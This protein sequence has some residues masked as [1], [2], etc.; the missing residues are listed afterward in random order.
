MTENNP[1]NVSQRE[2]PSVNSQ[3]YNIP[4]DSISLP[5]KGLLYSSDHPLCNEASVEIRC[6]TA[7]E[8]DLLT[9]AALVKNGTVLDKL[10]ES[11]LLNKTVEPGSL[12]LGDRSAILIAIRVSGY[13]SNYSV[14]VKCPSCFQEFEHDFSLN[15]LTVKSLGAEPVESNTNVFQ[16]V[17]P[18]SKST[19]QFKLLTGNDETEINSAHDKKKKLGVQVENAVTSRLIHQILSVDGNSDKSVISKFINTMRAGDSLSLRKY[20]N[21]ISPDVNVKQTMSCKYCN[22]ESEVGI[23]FGMSFFWPDV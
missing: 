6:M 19:V 2:V 8:E 13:G 1:F 10:M 18:L 23:P 4:V 14:K 16:Y 7:R 5:S 15:G 20:I 17:L 12:L 3:D 11:C 22:E 9:S 21:K